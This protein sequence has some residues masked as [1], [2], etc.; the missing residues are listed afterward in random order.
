M[1]KLSCAMPATP[2]LQAK[3]KK[4]AQNETTDPQ[5]KKKKILSPQQMEKKKQRDSLRRNIFLRTK[6]EEELS[7]GMS[8]RDIALKEQGFEVK[9]EEDNSEKFDFD[10]EHVKKVTFGGFSYPSGSPSEPA[11]SETGSVSSHYPV[12]GI[13]RKFTRK[14]I[15]KAIKKLEE[16]VQIEV[17]REKVDVLIERFFARNKHA[18]PR[19]RAAFKKGMGKEYQPVLNQPVRRREEKLSFLIQH[20]PICAPER[21]LNMHHHVSSRA[22][23]IL[24]KS[25]TA[26]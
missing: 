17:D 11:R 24:Q 7:K 8:F 12:R 18:T 2:S 22:K 19:A 16:K 4:D 14:L 15:T 6:E 1:V 20:P 23:A 25:K 5:K 26:K 21:K 13:M 9:Q 3:G 10:L